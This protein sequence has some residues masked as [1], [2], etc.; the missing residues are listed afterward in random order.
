[1]AETRKMLGELLDQ[2]F[3]SDWKTSADVIK[4]LAQRGLTLKGRQ[5]GEVSSTLAKMCQDS[6]TGLEREEIPK[7]KRVDKGIWKYKKVR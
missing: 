6:T 4:K 3:F 7:P 2:G 1:M 5:I